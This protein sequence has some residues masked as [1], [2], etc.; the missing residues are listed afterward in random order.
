MDALSPRDRLLLATA[1]LTYEGGVEA[2]GVDAIAERA[3]VTKR[4][5]YRQFGSKDALVGAALAA[6]GPLALASLRAAVQRRIDRGDQPVDALFA[7]LA[8][9]FAGETYRGCAFM[10]S[11]LEVADRGH[12]VHAAAREHTDGRRAL[13]AELCAAEGVEDPE[14]VDGILLLVEGAFTV[15]AAREDPDA[16]AR[17]GRAARRLLGG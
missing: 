2:T 14:V 15:S 4:T 16:A 10:N 5:L 7:T 17:A 9:L 1:E 8:R 12:P 13:V 6:R 11:S 3:G